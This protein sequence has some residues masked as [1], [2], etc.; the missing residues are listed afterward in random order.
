MTQAQMVTQMAAHLTKM[1]RLISNH[2]AHSQLQRERIAVAVSQK[3]PD[4]AD[5]LHV[6]IR[7]ILNSTAD[8]LSG[9][10]VWDWNADASQ[11]C[12]GQLISEHTRLVN[13]AASF[14]STA[15]Q[16]LRS[17]YPP[18]S[19]F[20]SPNHQHWNAEARCLCRD[21]QS[22]CSAVRTWWL[23]WP[24]AHMQGNAD[25]NAALVKLLGWI[26]EMQE[27]ALLV[28]F[29]QTVKCNQESWSTHI[30]VISRIS[31]FCFSHQ[32]GSQTMDVYKA[33]QVIPSM[34]F[35]IVCCLACQML[36]SEATEPG[37][38]PDPR[39]SS[40]WVR[41]VHTLLLDILVCMEDNV[42]SP[43]LTHLRTELMRDSTK[44]LTI[45]TLGLCGQYDPQEWRAALGAPDA[46]LKLLSM[47]AA[48]HLVQST[49]NPPAFS[50]SSSVELAT[51]TETS[52]GGRV[53]SSKNSGS[54]IGI[55]SSGSGSARRISRASASNDNVSSMFSSGGG[56]SGIT[57]PVLTSDCSVLLY[58]RVISVLHPR[59]R[60][61]V[62]ILICESILR[63]GLI[64]PHA[65]PTDKSGL[66]ILRGINHHGTLHTLL[67][68][69][70]QQHIAQCES[71]LLQVSKHA[72]TVCSEIDSN[73]K[74]MN[75]HLNPLNKQLQQERLGVSSDAGHA[76]CQTCEDQLQGRK[77]SS[78]QR[79]DI[80][81][82]LQQERARLTLLSVQLHK[83]IS[84]L[85]RQLDEIT[86]QVLPVF[87][88]IT[89]LPWML[90]QSWSTFNA[91]FGISGECVSL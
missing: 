66:D 75:E 54:D 31:L 21:I 15:A 57:Q 69:K 37:P 35:P 55:E 44:Q 73:H 38:R 68:M 65:S 63:S 43:A 88:G 33:T 4:L 25:L 14:L 60:P 45:L 3:P 72:G 34:L 86:A 46:V 6:E 28:E 7:A 70:Q 26:L 79:H 48:S 52:T 42:H 17:V 5:T 32:P 27:S 53:G 1:R 91:R 50:N 80:Y 77:P 90:S 62:N 47:F 20:S 18:H 12:L 51:D 85:N 40:S 22:V 64:T 76:E 67:W 39:E 29:T 84:S 58:G 78:P 36:M 10:E 23:K 24:C 11:T 30:L 59:S 13:T 82:R 41:F 9:L 71:S 74:M 19:P 81:Q 49:T 8:I 2:T 61:A 83:Q 87:S 56:S 89:A 16:R